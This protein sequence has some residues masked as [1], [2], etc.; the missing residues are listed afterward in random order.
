MQSVVEGKSL[1]DLTSLKMHLTRIVGSENDNVSGL[2]ASIV[3][4]AQFGGYKHYEC[5]RLL[6]EQ[7]V[8]SM[9]NSKH[10]GKLG[11]LTL[12]CSKPQSKTFK[13][14]LSF[15]FMFQWIW[16]IDE[17]RCSFIQI[18]S[19]IK[20]VCRC[21]ETDVYINKNRGVKFFKVELCERAS[22]SLRLMSVT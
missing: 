12:G 2:L 21:S 17:D 22:A 13:I 3:C 10:L 15:T 9:Q 1:V 19:V 5:F 18:I 8:Y 16:F 6:L 4:L 14:N 20:D 11:Q 7:N